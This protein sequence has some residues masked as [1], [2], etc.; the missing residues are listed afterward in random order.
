MYMAFYFIHE[1]KHMPTQI[2]QFVSRL[3]SLENPSQAHALFTDVDA[4]ANKGQRTKVLNALEGEIVKGLSEQLPANQVELMQMRAA[5][6]E[7]RVQ[8][9]LASGVKKIARELGP[10]A[11]L[12]F[13]REDAQDIRQGF[14]PEERAFVEGAHLL[15]DIVMHINARKG[16]KA[17]PLLKD[18]AAEAKKMSDKE[19]DSMYGHTR[20]LTTLA[21][22]QLGSTVDAAVAAVRKVNPFRF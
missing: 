13:G 20:L 2:E 9:E 14:D 4:I 15:G 11:D 1:G 3:N 17:A 5:L 18:Y 10:L 8:F 21:E 7:V 19:Y 16:D 6:A 22:K 12:L